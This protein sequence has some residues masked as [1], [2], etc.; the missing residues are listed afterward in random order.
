[1]ARQFFVIN[2]HEPEDCEPMDAG[3][4]RVPV[5]WKGKEFLCTC[6]AGEHGFYMV[7][8]GDSAEQVMGQLPAEW[9]P[10]TRAVPLEIFQL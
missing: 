10:G 1:M 8:E 2:R 5:A 9:R 3:I 4:A 6:P 7:V